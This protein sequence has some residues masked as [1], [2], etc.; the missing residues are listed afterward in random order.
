L[1]S[2]GHGTVGR[3]IRRKEKRDK[4]FGGEVENA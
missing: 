2:L 4:E 1:S 3:R